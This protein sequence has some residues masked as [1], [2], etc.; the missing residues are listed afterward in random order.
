MKTIAPGCHGVS[1]HGA[2]TGGFELAD[3]AR[4]FFGA[5]HTGFAHSRR[6]LLVDNPRDS[7]VGVMPGPLATCSP[8][9][10]AGTSSI[11]SVLLL[12]ATRRASSNPCIQ[13]GQ[14]WLGPPDFQV[15]DEDGKTHLLSDYQRKNRLFSWRFFPCTQENI[16]Q[17]D[18]AA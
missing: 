8:M 17:I 13:P 6:P 4:L 2:V 15:T 12:S 9:T 5:A 18:G 1:G 3:K 14:Y 10:I 11:F 7:G 16:A